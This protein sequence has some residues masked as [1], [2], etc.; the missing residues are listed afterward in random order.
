MNDIR[1]DKC[2]KRI[3]TN[4]LPWNIS[5]Y[6]LDRKWDTWGERKLRAK[7][8]EAKCVPNSPVAMGRYFAAKLYGW[9]DS[10][11]LALYALWNRESG[12]DPYSTNHAGS[13]ACGIPQFLP[14]RYYGDAR[15][16]IIAGLAYIEGRY[17]TPIAANGFQLANGWY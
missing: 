13:G 10:Q 4:F 5:P 15:S 3:P 14:C 1:H 7:E 2:L 16:Q 11:W 8:R 6:W 17:G 12:W 9:V